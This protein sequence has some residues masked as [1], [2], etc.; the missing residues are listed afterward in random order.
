MKFKDKYNCF[1]KSYISLRE[2]IESL[3]GNDLTEYDKKALKSLFKK[4]IHHL[5]VFDVLLTNK[6]FELCKELLIDYYL[7]KHVNLD[8][9]IKDHGSDLEILF[10]DIVEIGDESFLIEIFQSNE[11]PLSNLLSIWVFKAIQMSYSLDEVN[12]IPQWYKVSI[13]KKGV[14]KSD[15]EFILKELH[16][17]S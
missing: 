9:N 11:I 8:K 13:A 7:G 2:D 10:D 17:T 14:K 1:E 6:E 15:M 12:E 16:E 4:K 3:K 5:L